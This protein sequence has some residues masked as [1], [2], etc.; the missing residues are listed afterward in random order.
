MNNCMKAKMNFF[1]LLTQNM[2]K[3]AIV[4]ENKTGS[5]YKPK[6]S[7]KVVPGN[8]CISSTEDEGRKANWI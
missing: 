4:E 7:N 2:G 1:S 5:S 3:K 6:P 8:L